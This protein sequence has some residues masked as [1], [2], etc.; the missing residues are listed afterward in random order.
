MLKPED[1]LYFY[2]ILDWKTKISSL[3]P[4]GYL[5]FG[6]LLTH[7]FELI[8]LLTN[9]IAVG[10]VVIS[11]YS[12][13]D[14]IDWKTQNE[15]N[16]L[17]RLVKA[18]KLTNR[19]A[20]VWSLLPLLLTTG[21]IFTPS[22]FAQILFVLGTVL[23]FS[24]STPP[25]SLKG[26]RLLGLL[27]APLSSLILFLQGFFVLGHL[28]LNLILL[29]II[30][31]LFQFQT[32][33]LHILDDALTNEVVKKLDPQ[34]AL[35]WLKNLPL[36]SL[37]LGFIFSLLNYIFLI[38]VGFSLLRYLSFKDFKLSEVKK[39]RRNL[40][41]PQLSLTEFGLYALLSVLGLFKT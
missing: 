14:Y 40:F 33:L 37:V 12:F 27:V 20:L 24:Y 38:S 3:R 41:S 34:K 19:K 17:S 28:S 10:G 26:R 15:D 8:P 23:A 29:F 36:V 5:L 30:L 13:N 4:L 7:R 31:I 11:S 39:V 9:T 35:F 16:Y 21:I 32:D 25:F 6:Y 22:F 2:R 1:F 18:K